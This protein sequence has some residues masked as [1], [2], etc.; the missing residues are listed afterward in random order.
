ML[1][2]ALIKPPALS[3]VRKLSYDPFA[4]QQ[5][6]WLNVTVNEGFR[7]FVVEVR[8][9]AGRADGEAVAQVNPRAGMIAEE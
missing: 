2:S 3:K 1:G 4:H 8:E 6:I 9:A 5:V 7:E